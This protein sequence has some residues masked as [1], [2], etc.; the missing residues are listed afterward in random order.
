MADVRM[1]F[2]RPL[3]PIDLTQLCDDMST[4]TFRVAI[5]SA[6]FTDT[7]IADAFIASPAYHKVAVFNQ[8]DIA[9]GSRK[10]VSM[11]QEHIQHLTSQE[12]E[13]RE[14]W[15]TTFNAENPD[16]FQGEFDTDDL[17]LKHRAIKARYPLRH[18]AQAGV[19][20]S[21]DW[22]NG[23]MH[24]KFIVADDVA[25]F[26]SFNFTYNAKNNYETLARVEDT[27]TAT[28]FW[29][30]AQ[31]IA[32]D[33]HAWDESNLDGAHGSFLAKCSM[34]QKMFPADQVCYIDSHGSIACPECD[35]AVTVYED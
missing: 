7:S 28:L 18:Q 23:I 29:V 34:C 15:R 33:E 10:A 9:R 12:R 26:G 4:A 32:D 17:V 25:W 3:T 35:Q 19:I 31:C 6:W 16:Y 21:K 20:G 5:A 2:N 22:Q 1:F 30:E 14:L 24:H 11:V 27:Y 8:H 13:I